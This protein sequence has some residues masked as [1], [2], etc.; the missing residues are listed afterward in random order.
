MGQG[1]KHG[2]DTTKVDQRYAD[3]NGHRNN[4]HQ[5]VL[6]DCYPGHRPDAAG[7]DKSYK[8]NNRDRHCPG[9]TDA[10]EARDGYDDPDTSELELQVGNERGDAND[11]D[12]SGQIVIAVAPKEKIR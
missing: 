7:E 12:K 3:A 2:A 8:Q 4:E 5:G 1:G 9:A 10:V 6:D 11:A